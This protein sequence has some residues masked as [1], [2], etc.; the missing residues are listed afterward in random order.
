[1]HDGVLCI[2]CRNVALLLV[3]QGPGP[4]AG[5]MPGPWVYLKE[6]PDFYDDLE[7]K[8]GE[9]IESHVFD[10]DGNPQGQVLWVTRSVGAKA[11]EGIWLECRLVAC[12]DPHLKWWLKEGDGKDYGR[13]FGLHLCTKERAGC[14]KTKGDKDGEFHT[15][16]FRILTTSD[17]TSKKVTWMRSREVK[18]DIDAEIGRLEG[19][20]EKP[21]GKASS[22][23]KRPLAESSEEG[24]DLEVEPA[25]AEGEGKGAPVKEDLKRL[26]KELGDEA[27]DDKKDREKR[28]KR[29]E[30]PLP[31][32]KKG[33]EKEDRRKLSA[34]KKGSRASVNW[35]GQKK[36]SRSTTTESEK[37]LESTDSREGR[38]R[39]K[40][41]VKKKKARRKGDEDDRGPYGVG[42]KEKFVG[43]HSDKSDDSLSE[44]QVFRAAPSDKSRQLQLQ[45]YA[46]EHPGRLASRL[47]RKMRTLLAREEG[48]MKDEGG[49]SLTPSTATSYFLTV[50][51]PT[52]QD[53]LN[54]RMK[55]EMKTVA[56]ALDQVAAGQGPQAADTLAQRLKAL[57]L[58]VSDQSWSRAQHLELLPPEGAALVDKDEAYMAT[59]EQ[60][61]DV[62]MRTAISGANPKGKG[63]EDGPKGKGKKGKGGHVKGWGGAQDTEKAPPV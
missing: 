15:D 51:V 40:K 20:K 49:Q 58:Q 33:E 25:E 54:L 36:P 37:T 12:S 35:F 39:K 14:K 10:Q 5:E 61:V 8:K 16:Y 13:I 19:Q 48:A 18:A 34:D 53:K 32:G 11:K 27:R 50:M 46:E 22:S 43:S 47:L 44:G 30:K 42:R 21:A 60:A 59:K 29:K 4:P 17:V 23:K 1:M 45:E 56:R 24:N 63:K 2:T 57:E 31:E 62:K 52:Y 28:Q 9:Y 41:K 7:V 3:V 55:R 38:R 26:R 6:N